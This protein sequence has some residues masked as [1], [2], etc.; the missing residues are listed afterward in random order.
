MIALTRREARVT[1]ARILRQG[2]WPTGHEPAVTAAV[3]AA[4][5]LGLPALA[6]LDHDWPAIA[7]SDPQ[8]LQV[9][10]GAID[11]GGMHALVALPFIVD[12]LVERLAREDGVSARVTGA[13]RP[14]LLAAIQAF[15][16]RHGAAFTMD[17]TAVS[18]LRAAAPPRALH[19]DFAVDAALWRR[20]CV[21]AEAYLVPES[22][23]SRRHAGSS[24]SAD[25]SDA[26]DAG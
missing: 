2:A 19:G 18:A 23:I 21:R 25:G 7:A 8:H 15:G 1:V 4:E 9:A 17:G 14:E 24:L 26:G 22:E 20:L 5:G 11:C 3:L 6:S 12:L 13:V 10:D 16:P